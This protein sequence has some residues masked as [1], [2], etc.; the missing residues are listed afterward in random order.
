MTTDKSLVK[1]RFCSFI[2]SVSV[3]LGLAV[4]PVK[5]QTSSYFLV[6]KGQIFLQTAAAAPA[7]A[8]SSAAIFEAETP[9]LGGPPTATN[10]TVTFPGG[11]SQKMSYTSSGDLFS[12]TNTAATISVLDT[13]YPAGRYSISLSLSYGYTFTTN[14]TLPADNFPSAPQINNFTAAQSLDNTQ[15]FILVFQPFTGS[16]APSTATLELYN[17]GAL[18]SSQSL[19]LTA[20]NYTIAANTLAANTTYDARLRFENIQASGTSF[21]IPASG[22]F[23]E[24]RFSLKTVAGTINQT[25]PVLTNAAPV[26]GTVLP[27]PQSGLVLQFNKPMDESKIA[28]LWVATLNGAAFALP[29]TNF[30]YTWSDTHTLACLYAPLA[31]GWPDGAQV[32]W[33]LS[34]TPGNPSNFADINGDLLATN[35]YTG[36][37]FTYGGPW[38]CAVQT[39]SPLEAPAF[40]LVKAGNFDQ[41]S[42]NAAVPDATAGGQLLAFYDGPPGTAV[43]LVALAAPV[44]GSVTESIKILTASQSANVNLRAFAAS[45]ATTSALDA[46]YPPGN[47]TIELGMPNPTN[48]QAA[49]VTTNSASM[50]LTSA[51]YPPVPHFS[52]FSAAQSFAVSNSFTLAWDSYSTANTDSS[53]VSLKILDAASN[54]VFSAPNSCAGVALSSSSTSVTIP[55]NT[56]MAT[57]T[58]V[59]ALSFGQLVTTPEVMPGIPGQGYS[60]LEIVTRLKLMVNAQGMVGAPPAVSITSPTPGS[61]LPS[62]NISFQIAVSDSAA[63]LTQLQLFTGTNLLATMSTPAGQSNFNGTISGVFTPGPQAVTVIATDANGNSGTSASLPILVRD[64]NFIVNL[65]NP[66]NGSIYPPYSTIQIAANVTSPHGSVTNVDFF[67]D[68]ADL[69]SLTNSPYLISIPHVVPG[70]HQFYARA[71][72]TTGNVGN[73]SVASVT[74]TAP[75]LNHLTPFI[76]NN[77]FFAA[78]FSGIAKSNYVFETATNLAPPVRWTPVQTKLLSGAQTVFSDAT[79]GQYPSGFYRIVPLPVNATNAPAFSVWDQPNPAI[80]GT[81]TYDW[82][83]GALTSI[84]N[85]D[86]TLYSLTIPPGAMDLSEP[87]VMTLVTNLQDYPLTGALVAAVNIAPSEYYLFVQGTLTI[88]L[89]PGISATQLVA[90]TYHQPN[91]EFFLTPFQTTNIVAGS[92]TNPAVS[93]T[94]SRLGGY[95]LAMLKSADLALAAQ[96]RPSDLADRFDQITALALLKQSGAAALSSSGAPRSGTRTIAAARAGRRLMDDPVLVQ[97]FLDRFDAIYPQ[98]QAAAATGEWTCQDYAAWRRWVTDLYAAGLENSFSIQIAEIGRAQNSMVEKKINNLIQSANQQHDW[99][100]LIRLTIF[101]SSGTLY[102]PGHAPYWQPGQLEALQKAIDACLT[103]EL[104]MDSSIVNDSDIG[105]ETSHIKAMFTFSQGNPA[106][107][108]QAKGQA[109]PN[110]V[111]ATFPPVPNCGAATAAPST[112]NFIVYKFSPTGS[113]SRSNGCSKNYNIN[114]LSALVWPNFPAENFSMVCEGHPVTVPNFWW[115]EFGYLHESEL[116]VY[117]EN[118]SEVKA[119]PKA[120]F[121]L[122]DGWQV[123]GGG[124]NPVLGTFK[125]NNTAGFQNATITETTTMTLTHTPQ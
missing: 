55:G 82:D 79:S 90:F 114:G 65:L 46:A 1:T 40:Y 23:S 86:G 18:L 58:Y 32:T 57:Q 72:D 66:A 109:V 44:L 15:P 117:P 3:V 107:R 88:Q 38:N 37:F 31:G 19:A 98:M 17:N 49:F 77:G 74:V 105:T 26:N 96:F 4:L 80:S 35:T 120:C 111:E 61:L 48:T 28:I 89:P 95:G 118:P 113:T 73:S 41:T 33:T 116:T 62:G 70:P 20:T 54:V 9:G 97:Q 13:T 78:G 101:D 24:T 52:N 112:P 63:A 30:F 6:A 22:F 100:D 56:L 102:A 68:G 110:W 27:A 12:F 93:I 29:Q 123:Q 45:F 14:I 122:T 25:P 10:A 91:G 99:P 60:A 39:A 51:G 7:P 87:V 69:G 36:T 64:P 119:A 81:D 85:S 16:V 47:Y 5:A 8:S 34:P 76:L 121:R 125:A 104:D 2:V 71:A 115:P 59:V 94:V 124:G 42:V 106:Q 67:M 92:V 75:P 43:P 108:G 103:F 50:A 53:F 21:P 83:E 84:T 11:A